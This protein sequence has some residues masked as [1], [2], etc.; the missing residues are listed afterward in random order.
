MGH[1]AENPVHPSLHDLRS[2]LHLERLEKLYKIKLDVLCSK[3]KC[4][5]KSSTCIAISGAVGGDWPLALVVRIRAVS[6][7][8]HLCMGGNDHLLLSLAESEGLTLMPWR[9][10][11]RVVAS[12]D[13]DDFGGLMV[14]V[15]LV[16]TLMS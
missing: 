2:E 13:P 11:S 10:D 12:S 6:K 7:A 16:L 3:C 9:S 4:A 8:R 14:V 15:L 1:A 5:T